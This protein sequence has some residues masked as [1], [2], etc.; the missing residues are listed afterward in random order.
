[1]LG[2]LTL[3]IK[4]ITQG[5]LQH[6]KPNWKMPQREKRREGRRERRVKGLGR[7]VKGTG[8]WELCVAAGHRVEKR[9]SRK[10]GG[11]VSSVH[12]RRGG[13]GG[14]MVPKIGVHGSG[15]R[16]KGDVG[17]FHSARIHEKKRCWDVKIVWGGEEEPEKNQ[18]GRSDGGHIFWGSPNGVPVFLSYR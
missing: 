17:I 2:D 16:R 3:L 9:K 11:W 15:N 7:R 12:G 5:T 18:G 14:R 8:S 4:E 6:L 13:T 1:L 10:G